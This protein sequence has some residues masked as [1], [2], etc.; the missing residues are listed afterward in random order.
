MS[1]WQ[2]SALLQLLWV[3]FTVWGC[4]E[5]AQNKSEIRTEIETA[6]R[7]FSAATV[8]GDTAVI[9]GLYTE[10]AYLYP[11]GRTIHGREA[12]K[13]Y[14][15][16]NPNRTVLA[17]QMLSDTL[18]IEG[19]IAVD[20]GTWSITTQRT[21]DSAQSVTDRYLVIWRRD[22][23]GKWRMEYDMWHRPAN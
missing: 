10:S 11:P 13:R 14:F 5:V 22:H 23:N 8:R 12:I 9:G 19:D 15:A 21:G 6:S 17:H 7:E 1:R 16:P 3:P 20:V 2:R 4:S 18:T